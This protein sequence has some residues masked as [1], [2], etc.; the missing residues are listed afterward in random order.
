LP[1]DKQVGR[2][3]SRGKTTSMRL[4]DDAGGRRE[5]LEAYP[6]YEVGLVNPLIMIDE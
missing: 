4:A 1:P 5:R 3:V 2:L 6:G